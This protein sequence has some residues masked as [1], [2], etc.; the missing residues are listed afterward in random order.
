MGKK[1]NWFSALKRAFTSSSK[2]KLANEPDKI[3]PKEKKKWG[4][5][6]TRHGEASSFM[7]LY[8]E[9]S[10]IEKILGDAK[11]S[12]T[13]MYIKGHLE[14]PKWIKGNGH[15]KWLKREI[16]KESAAKVTAIAT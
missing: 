12:R 14:M 8:R 4:F 9:P 1:G 10:S 2:D 6:R 15:I 13:G 7:P 3:Y 11:G 16:Q 5:T